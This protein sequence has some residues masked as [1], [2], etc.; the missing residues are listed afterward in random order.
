MFCSPFKISWCA[1]VAVTPLINKIIVFKRGTWKAGI[2]SKPRLGHII[3]CIDNGDNL[4]WK[5]AQNT[6]KKNQTSL[7]RNQI[8]PHFNPLCTKE[9][10]WPWYALS[11]FISRNHKT[12]VNNT[13]IKQKAVVKIEKLYLNHKTVLAMKRN[14]NTLILIGNHLLSTTWESCHA[15]I[16]SFS[17]R[18]CAYLHYKFR[19][20]AF[21][22]IRSLI[23]TL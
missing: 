9:V 3:M 12:K 6:L 2:G 20:Q 21:N 14:L 5:K 17:K 13:R 23:N 10:C 15:L 19:V 11:R 4:L 22:K 8:K 16:S 7:K 1:K 18:K